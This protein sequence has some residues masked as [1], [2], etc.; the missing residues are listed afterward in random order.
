MDKNL[1]KQF[2]EQE[3]MRKEV[4]M[5]IRENL[6]TLAVEMVKANKDTTNLSEAYK[7]I[8]RTEQKLTAEF[9]QKPKQNIRQRS[10]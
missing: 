8:D 2:Y 6:N 9:S 3:H 5:F 1:L 10:V 4:F 7:A